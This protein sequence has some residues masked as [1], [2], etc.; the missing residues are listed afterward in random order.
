MLKMIS[1]DLN[2]IYDL[3]RDGKFI[4]RGTA[5]E[6]FMKLQKIQSASADWAIKYEGYTI[7]PVMA[8]CQL[9]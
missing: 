4:F 2:E 1:A 3:R 7:S 6:C 9:M 8:N 5:N